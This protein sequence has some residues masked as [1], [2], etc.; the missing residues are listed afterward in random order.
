MP[1]AFLVAPI[2]T[3]AHCTQ[4][5]KTSHMEV[6]FGDHYVTVDDGEERF[7]VCGKIKNPDY[8]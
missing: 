2:V 7:A 6:I 5:V 3:A 4:G 8:E 1:V